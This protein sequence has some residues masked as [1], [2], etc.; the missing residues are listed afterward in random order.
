MPDNRAHGEREREPP[1]TSAV[2]NAVIHTAAFSTLNSKKYSS[3]LSQFSNK[4]I[5]QQRNNDISSERNEARTE[6]KSYKVEGRRDILVDT[7]I[8]VHEERK[9]VINAEFGSVENYNN[10]KNAD[11]ISSN[12]DSMIDTKKRLYSERNKLIK[13]EYGSH[14]NYKEACSAINSENRRNTLVE[15]KKSLIQERNSLVKSGDVSKEKRLD[16]VNNRISKLDSQIKIES[17]NIKVYFDKRPDAVDALKASGNRKNLSSLYAKSERLNKVDNHYSKLTNDINRS[18]AKLKTVTHSEKPESLIK[19]DKKLNYFDGKVN[20]CS[21]KLRQHS[22]RLDSILNERSDSKYFR[23]SRDGHFRSSIESADKLER[24]AARAEMKLDSASRGVPRHTIVRKSYQFDTET[25]KVK[26]KLILEKEVKSID[27]GVISKGLKGAS[28]VTAARLGASIH[29]ELRKNENELQNVGAKAAHTAERAV[30]HGV[31]KTVKHAHKFLKERP[32][33]KVS[34]LQLKSDKANARLYARKKGGTARQMRKN[35]KQYMNR[36][37]QMRTAQKSAGAVNEAIKALS[38]LVKKLACNPYFW[39]IVAIVAVIILVFGLIMSAVTSIGGNS[40]SI[41]GAYLSADDEIYAAEQYAQSYEI[42]AVQA[43]IN[44]IT[45]AVNHDVLIINPYTFNRNPYNLIS[46]LS[47]YSFTSSDD[48]YDNSFVVNNAIKAVIER[49]INTYYYVLYSTYE[50]RT[51][52]FYG[53]DDDG[54]PI[55]DEIVTIY[56]TIDVQ[57][58]TADE[59]VQSIFNSGSPYT[60]E[61]YELYNIYMETLGFRDDLFPAWAN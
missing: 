57:E 53:Y 34:K 5:V 16:K 12:R 32:Y 58:R 37:K 33:K 13:S 40:G 22:A 11:K 30:E 47:A 44:G 24:K 41:L 23:V 42:T 38:L 31:T 19:A 60:L 49:F 10:F 61:M 26:K 20:K 7:K 54:Y 14:A 35:A 21:D 48:E 2:R 56:L 3:T 39:L 52:V 27:G 29:K 25:G 6:H 28:M 8:S 17:A 9:A 1:T 36:A 51:T 50:V 43:T 4:N 15:Q 46:F 55:Y 45:S 59:V 18:T